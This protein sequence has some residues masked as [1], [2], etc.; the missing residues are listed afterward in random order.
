HGT[1]PSVFAVM[2]PEAELRIEWRAPG[3]AIQVRRDIFFAVFGMDI[4]LPIVAAY[5]RLI[6]QAEK[7]QVGVI[8]EEA[9]RGVLH[10]YQY[11]RAVRERAK[12]LLAFTQN[13][14]FTLPL[15][16]ITGDFGR[17]DDFS[18]CASNW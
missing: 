6:P 18:V 10:P 3:Q 16:Y 17:P 7:I 2:S 13:A 12:P 8:Y 14:L 11:W 9:T 1:H 15:G 5:H 4:L